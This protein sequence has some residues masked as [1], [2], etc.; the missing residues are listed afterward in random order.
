MTYE[1]FSE[2]LEKLETQEKRR[3]VL[4]R[5][6]LDLIDYSDPYEYVIGRLFIEIYGEEGW[7]WLSWFMYENDCG[8]KGYE[9]RDENGE[10]ICQDAKSTW[11]FLETNYNNKK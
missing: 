6:G 9:A 5:N 7:D 4:Y 1:K 2:I 10:L 3:E 11:E 8:Q